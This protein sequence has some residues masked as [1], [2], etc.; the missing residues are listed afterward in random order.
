M[1]EY[2]NSVAPPGLIGL[3]A[4]A[5]AG[6]LKIASVAMSARVSFSCSL[7]VVDVLRCW[8]SHVVRLSCLLDV[9][10]SRQH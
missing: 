2:E 10:L 8:A 7:L 4:I 3:V 1:I 9:D 6:T 5:V